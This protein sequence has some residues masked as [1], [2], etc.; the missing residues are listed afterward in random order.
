LITLILPTPGHGTWAAAV[1]IRG[2]VR[3]LGVHTAADGSVTVHSGALGT[4]P[5]APTS[6]D[7]CTDGAYTLYSGS[8]K[9]TLQWY[10]NAST[11]P[12]EVTQDNAKS[13]LRS[14]VQ[15]IT[16]AHNNC[17]LSDHVSAKAAYQGTTTRDTNIGNSSSCKSADG[18]SVVA[19]GDLAATDLAFTC[20]WS[21]GNT[22]VEADMRL[23]KVEYSWVVNIGGNC[24]TKFS[25][26]AVAT[27]EFGHAYGLGHVDEG[28][29]G[30]LTM[31]PVFLPCQASEATLG[32]GDVRGLEAKY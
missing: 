17:G 5:T 29:H 11:T 14:A 7:P 9:S 26:E 20:W 21:S 24:V 25:V 3:S 31:S 12:N 2:H 13:A 4:G 10:F 1:D 23:N 19:F 32:L 30:A 16:L 8:W 18:K 6:P 28:L 27:H 22:T 15:N